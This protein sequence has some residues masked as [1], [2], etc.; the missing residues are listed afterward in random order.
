MLGVGSSGASAVELAPGIGYDRLEQPGPQVVHVLTIRPGPLVR[1]EAGLT[2]GTPARR[3]TL[4]GAMRVRL[5]AGAVAGVNGDYFNLSDAYPSGVLALPGELVSEPEASRSAVVLGLDG[6]M[7]VLR[8]Q[9][10]GRYQVLDP[11]VVPPP[12]VRTFSGVNRPFERSS[13]VVVFTP[14]FGATTPTGASRTEAVVALDGGVALVP[15]TVPQGTVVSVATGPGGTPIGPG[16]VVIAA[17][18]AAGATLA[19][20]LAPGRRL[21]LEAAV[22]GLPPQGQALGG[23]PL[24]VQSGVAIADAGEGFTSGQTGSRTA[25]TAVGQRADGT[26]LLVTS[27]GPQQGRRGFTVA[28]QGALMVS[29]GAQTALGMDSGGSA[30]MSIGDR[31]AIPWSSERPI[32]DALFVTYLGARIDPF[33]TERISPN[34]DGVDDALDAVVRAPV[35]GTLRVALT[36]R[37]GATT[38]LSEGPTGP[39]SASI[40]VDP[41]VL[42]VADGPYVVSADLTPVDA[43]LPS[44]QRRRI[45]IDRTLGRLTARPVRRKGAR[46]VEVG[47]TLARPA[48]VTLRI[49]RA[50]GRVIRVPVASR[51]LRRGRQTLVWDATVKRRP[52]SGDFRV[53]V[54]ARTFLGATSL[55]RAVRLAPDVLVVTPTAP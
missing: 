46:R 42:G 24:L 1:L 41:R 30:L 51:G 44:S 35:A 37:G 39:A 36:R 17:L 45:V 38:V 29:L 23:G 27:E 48:R 14:R 26:Y 15:N 3:G 16:Q 19:A 52:V 18:G 54:E 2:A 8:L 12:P 10:A 9:L 20:D 31:L 21:S 5:D 50:D 40:R 28:E 43:G 55:S 53:E 25:R 22:A 32:T 34:G 47:F 4:T 13:E 33:A 7:Q 11:I 6:A 49:A